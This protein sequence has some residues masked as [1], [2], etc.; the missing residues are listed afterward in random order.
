MKP[1]YR[2]GR[3]ARDSFEETMT[4]LFRVP[5]SAVKDKPKPAPKPKKKG[6]D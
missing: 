1:E 4:A 6:K 5:K 2:S 3:D